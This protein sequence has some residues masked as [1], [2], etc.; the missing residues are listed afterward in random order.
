[1]SLIVLYKMEFYVYSYNLFSFYSNSCVCKKRQKTYIQ[2]AKAHDRV[3]WKVCNWPVLELDECK[4]MSH[5][6]LLECR[7]R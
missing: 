4:I 3:D 6:Y 7:I 5:A 1:M 2:I